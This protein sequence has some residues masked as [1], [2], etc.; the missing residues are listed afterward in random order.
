MLDHVTGP[1][2]KHVRFSFDL[3]RLIRSDK[4]RPGDQ[5]PQCVQCTGQ[6]VFVYG[7]LHVFLHNG[8]DG[9]MSI[10]TFVGGIY[11]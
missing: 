7:N 6:R 3:D 2:V 4:R 5:L 1:E 10:L 8:V 9:E 11:T